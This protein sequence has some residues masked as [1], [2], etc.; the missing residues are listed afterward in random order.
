MV[1]INAIV[2]TVKSSYAILDSDAYYAQLKIS[3]TNK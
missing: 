2:I 3:K 1:T